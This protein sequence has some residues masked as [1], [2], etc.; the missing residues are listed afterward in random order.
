MTIPSCAACTSLPG[1]SDA[2]PWPRDHPPDVAA[3]VMSQ[4]GRG[5]DV[6]SFLPSRSSGHVRDDRYENGAC[7]VDRGCAL[8]PTPGHIAGLLRRGEL[9]REPITTHCSRWRSARCKRCGIHLVHAPPDVDRLAGRLAPSPEA[10]GQP[11]PPAGYAVPVDLRINRP[12]LAG[13]LDKTRSTRSSICSTMKSAPMS[14]R[15][16]VDHKSAT[17]VRPE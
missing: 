7:A 4:R 1:G 13:P 16:P 15:A 17:I 14:M 5:A 10:S 3:A 12:P 8:N 11:R 9:G 2:V 6:R